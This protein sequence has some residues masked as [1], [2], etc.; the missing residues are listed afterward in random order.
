MISNDSSGYIPKGPPED[1]TNYD[2]IPLTDRTD[3][4]V[5]RQLAKSLSLLAAGDGKS[6]CKPGR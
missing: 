5:D 1:G 3:Y 4:R 6:H 2:E